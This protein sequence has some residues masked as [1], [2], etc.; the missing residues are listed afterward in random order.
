MAE[1]A[2]N[3]VS[4][5]HTSPDTVFS[6][7][8]FA[9]PV[10]SPRGGVCRPP[11]GSGRGCRGGSR[12]H[13]MAAP[14]GGGPCAVGRPCGVAFPLG[15]QRGPLLFSHDLNLLCSVMCWLVPLFLVP[16]LAGGFFLWWAPCPPWLPS[17]P[18]PCHGDV[19]CRTGWSN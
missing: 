9:G 12:D 14:R 8:M 11:A 19:A 10:R 16:V 4:P 2:I 17:H 6:T 18:Q 7:H 3:H 13:L 15:N 1:N 5:P